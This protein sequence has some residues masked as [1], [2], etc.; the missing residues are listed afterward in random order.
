METNK[1]DIVIENRKLTELSKLKNNAHYMDK[2]EFDQLVENIKRDGVLTSLP[3][4]Y[5]KDIPGEILSGNHRVEAAIKAGIESA[6]V[7]VIKSDLTKDQKLGIQLS[8]NAIHGKDDPNLLKVLYDSIE[9]IDFKNYSGLT[10]DAFKVNEIDLT[11]LSFGN[12][13][14]E[15]LTISFLPEDKQAFIDNLERI[16]KLAKKQNVVVANRSDFDLFF[17]TMLTIKS[18]YAILNHSIAINKMLELANKQIELERQE[19]AQNDGSE[20]NTD[21]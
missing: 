9:S 15:D 5:D 8:H 13:K 18:E 14:A 19:K 3:V 7:I 16:K 12:V 4:V 2:A 10:D 6:D 1:L 20:E 11:A 17:E 21:N